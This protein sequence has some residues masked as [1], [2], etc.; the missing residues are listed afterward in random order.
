ME[1]KLKKIKVSELFKKYK[2]SGIN[3]VK[4]WDGKLDI[5]PEFQREFIYKEKQRNEVIYTVLKHFPLNVMYFVKNYNDHFE[6]LDGQQRILSLCQ[7]M[8]GEFSIIDNNNNVRYFRSLEKIEKNKILDYELQVYIC[9]GNDK[10]KLD[11]FQIINIAGETLSN[12]ELKNAIYPGKWVTS[13]KAHFSK[14]GGAIYGSKHNKYLRGNGIRQDFLETAIKWKSNNNIKD[15]MA[16]HQFDSDATPLWHYFDQVIN[17]SKST[18]PNYRKEMKGVEWGFLYNKYK[19][20]EQNPNKLEK[21]IKKLMKDD[22]VTN[23][24]GIYEYVLSGNEKAL[25]IRSFTDSEKRETY[26]RQN[27]KCAICKKA[28]SF[29]Q[30]EADHIKPWSQGGRTILQN[31]QML[32]KKDNRKKSNI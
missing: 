27:G 5:R 10:E 8:N 7:F 6:V 17:W 31:C 21:K 26:E 19:N 30:M 20:D 11:W 29:E 4:G 12:Q 25:S 13:A 14:P 22:D 1:I 28:F 23:K 32:C 3:G 9:E 2:D 18:F 15:Y 16:D 24:K